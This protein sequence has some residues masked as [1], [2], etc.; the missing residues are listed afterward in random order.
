MILCL[1]V[2]LWIAPIYSNVLIRIDQMD[3]TLF[4]IMN[5]ASFF[6]MVGSTGIINIVRIGYDSFLRQKVSVLAC[7]SSKCYLSVAVARK[8]SACPKKATSR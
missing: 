8:E 5:K 3:S 2:A 4:D 1:L 7:R 6:C